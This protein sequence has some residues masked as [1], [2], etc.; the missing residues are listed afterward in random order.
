MA[1]SVER[2]ALARDPARFKRLTALRCAA[3]SIVERVLVVVTAR[4]GSG[5]PAGAPRTASRQVCR[6]LAAPLVTRHR[7]ARLAQRQKTCASI[8]TNH[9]TAVRPTRQA[10]LG[11][12]T[13]ACAVSQRKR[14]KQRHTSRYCSGQAFERA[15]FVIFVLFFAESYVRTVASL[16]RV[17]GRRLAKKKKDF[18][19]TVSFAMLRRSPRSNQVKPT[20]QRPRPPHRKLQNTASNKWS[21]KYKVTTP[22][23]GRNRRWQSASDTQVRKKKIEHKKNHFFFIFFLFRSAPARAQRRPSKH[24]RRRNIAACVAS[25]RT[26]A[27]THTRCDGTA[28]R[29]KKKKFAFFCFFFA[30]FGTRVSALGTSQHSPTQARRANRQRTVSHRTKLMRADCVQ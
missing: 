19:I 8:P 1:D 21:R 13:C 5:V 25:A 27:R 14:K 2:C 6:S 16:H 23:A 17:A 20:S 22:I 15:S 24:V 10:G 12:I 7:V 4:V 29:K 28:K 9:A 26:L 11:S 18:F 3:P 30:F